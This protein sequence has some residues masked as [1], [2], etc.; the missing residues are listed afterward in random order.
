[1]YS[2]ISIVGV[3]LSGKENY[4]EWS[5]KIKY[6]LIFNELW[7]EECEGVHVNPL[8]KPTSS[9]ELAIWE[10]KINKAYALIAML[11]NEEVSRCIAPFTNAFS[12]LK[13]LKDL[14]DLHFELEVVQL[15]IKLSNIE[16]KYDDPLALAFEIKAIVH[17][18]EAT[19]V[20]MG[21]PLTN[22]VK[23]LYPTYSHYLES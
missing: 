2:L 5:I 10:N 11:I 17:D 19:D 4:H 18:V 15:K 8:E 21:V 14:Y 13:K 23:E 22:Y 20:K 3:V 12:A 1:M 16:L 7:K 6:T 9:K